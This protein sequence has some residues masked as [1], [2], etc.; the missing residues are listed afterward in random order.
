[1]KELIVL[2]VATSESIIPVIAL[3][4]NMMRA[5]DAIRTIKNFDGRLTGGLMTA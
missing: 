3:M 1:M 4:E 5:G 2:V